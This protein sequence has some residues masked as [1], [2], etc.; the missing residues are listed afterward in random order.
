MS[1]IFLNSIFPQYVFPPETSSL[2]W[3][4]GPPREGWE[5][6][7]FHFPSVIVTGDE[8]SEWLIDSQSLHL[9]I[10][11][12][13]GMLDDNTK[14][15]PKLTIYKWNT[16]VQIRSALAFCNIVSHKSFDSY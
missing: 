12:H 16:F 4:G 15:A 5:I 3:C 1:T 14:E 11:W 2:G 8:K 6:E 7:Y 10:N 9:P 13:S